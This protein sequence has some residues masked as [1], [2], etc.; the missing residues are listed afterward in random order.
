MANNNFRFLVQK[1]PGDSSGILI[2][3]RFRK[4]AAWKK[5]INFSR[6][7][8]TF[9]W[10]GMAEELQSITE[11][12]ARVPMPGQSEQFLSALN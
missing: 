6:F 12:N 7:L 10:N 3:M 11:P 2:G 1:L 8:I 5:L 9:E 4:V